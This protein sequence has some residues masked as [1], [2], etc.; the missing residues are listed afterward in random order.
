MM[1]RGMDPSFTALS[2]NLQAKTH[3]IEAYIPYS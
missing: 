3:N 1:A 2:T